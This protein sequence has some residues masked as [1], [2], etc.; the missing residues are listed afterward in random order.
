[1]SS[2]KQ[3]A[4][5]VNSIE[6]DAER[7][8]ETSKTLQGWDELGRSDDDEEEYDDEDDDDDDEN[9]DDGENYDCACDE[10][11]DGGDF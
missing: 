9:D 10:N 4:A 8:F 2:L 6:R 11:G 7:G 5:I 1:M 3:T